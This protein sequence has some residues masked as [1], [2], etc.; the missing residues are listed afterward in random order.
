MS[1]DLSLRRIQILLSELPRYTRKSIHVAG[2]NGKGSVTAYLSHI[3]GAASY[4]V[5]RFNSP[6]LL[7]I[8]DCICINNKAISMGE[9]ERMKHRVLDVDSRMKIGCTSFELLTATAFQIFEDNQVDVAV[10]EVGMGGRLDATNALPDDCVVASAITSIDLDHQNFLGD[11]I[12]A[13]A[14]EKAGIARAGVP[15]ILAQQQSPSVTDVVQGIARSVGA[16]LISVVSIEQED[17]P[18]TNRWKAFLP[19]MG[20]SI[21]GLMPLRGNYQLENLRVALTVVDSIQTAFPLKTGDIV[22]GVASTTWPGRLQHIHMPVDSQ[23]GS[24]PV[25]IELL[26]DG[27]HNAAAAR[28]LSDYLESLPR[29]PRRFILS[30]SSSPTKS[31]HPIL[32]P[33]LRPGDEVHVVPF[34]PVE[35]M[36]WIKPRSSSELS[37]VA[38]ELVGA[39]GVVHEWDSLDCALRSLGEGKGDSCTVVAGSLYLV[40]DVLRLLRSQVDS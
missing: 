11:T 3:L 27:A 30:L 21:S 33:I 9:Y 39:T 32:S 35:N 28:L 40:A 10:I 22:D 19:R 34:G 23:S 2:T 24:D 5:G 25:S 14:R 16:P 18:N 6:H 1:I 8:W 29:R 20:V 37:I 36:P 4:K 26:L 7:D 17:A 38:S 13:I 15:L 31:P 12:E